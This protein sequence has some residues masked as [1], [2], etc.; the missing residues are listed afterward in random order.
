M[1][2]DFVKHGKL[3]APASSIVVH[4][5]GLIKVPISINGCDLCCQ[6]AILESAGQ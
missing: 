5:K 6:P 2:A 3:L 1:Q 4:I